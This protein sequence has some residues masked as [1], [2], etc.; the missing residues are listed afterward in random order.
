MPKLLQLNICVNWGSTGKIVEQIG[1]V[2]QSHGWESYIAYGRY[3]NPSKNKVLR[4]GCMLDTY[5]HYLLHRFFDKEG[6]GSRRATKKLIKQ[7]DSIKP[8]LVH[9]HNIHD[10]YLNYPL[11]FDYLAGNNIPVVWTQ[12]DLWAITGHCYYSADGCEK[13]KT[14]CCDCPLIP[15]FCMDRSKQ[16][17]AL[18]SASFTAVKHMTI[19]PVSNWLGTQIRQSYLNKYPIKVIKNGVDLNVFKPISFSITEKYGIIGKKILLGVAS[20]FG[21]SKGLQD[22]IELSK[23]LPEDFVIILVGLS[24]DQIMVLPDKILGL[25]RTNNQI[26]LAQLYSSADI[27][28]SLSSFETFGLTIAEGMACGTP[29]IV[30]NNAALPDLITP[31]TGYVVESGNIQELFKTIINMTS[32]GFKEK[33]SL[34]C[35]RRAEE[36]FDKNKSWESCIALYDSIMGGVK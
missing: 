5:T 14:G 35:R 26:E 23:L 2:A 19:V 27:I 13:W 21:N 28:L 6:L 7:L 10:H 32:I 15:I 36:E 22:Y 20:A 16:N 34:D 12:H 33:H 8:D 29:A 24:K 31:E 18:K 25:E 3:I 9:L 4:I 30:Y 17:Y 11:L 1:L